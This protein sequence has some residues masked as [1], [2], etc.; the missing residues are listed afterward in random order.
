MAGGGDQP[1]RGEFFEVPYDCS[2]AHVEPFFDV[3]PGDSH[4]AAQVAENR[5]LP[6]VRG[7]HVTARGDIRFRH[8]DFARGDR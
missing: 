4:V 6:L 8:R 7:D 5:F 1:H 3:R 2:V